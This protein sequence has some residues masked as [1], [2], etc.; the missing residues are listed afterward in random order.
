MHVY[1]MCHGI[2]IYAYICHVPFTGCPGGTQP[3][4]GSKRSHFCYT[5]QLSHDPH[6]PQGHPRT[7]PYTPREPALFQMPPG[8]CSKE[9]LGPPE[10]LPRTPR[11]LQS[12]THR[13]TECPQGFPLDAQAPPR[14]LQVPPKTPEKPQRSPQGTQQALKNNH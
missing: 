11:D 1:R 6:H 2:Y 4:D 10:E 5:I 12:D 7:P 13:T 14:D 3:C 8:T 9:P